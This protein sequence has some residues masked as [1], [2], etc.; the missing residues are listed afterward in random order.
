MSGTL[1]ASL[2]QEEAALK[3]QELVNALADTDYVKAIQLAFELRRP[4]KLLN[5]F[6]EL[7][8]LAL[9]LI[10]L[11]SLFSRML[12]YFSDKNTHLFQQRVC[13]RSD[14]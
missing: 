6:I 10:W 7:Y 4:Y 2:V 12:H 1:Y 13:Q 11:M 3:D 14:T 9:A 5:V 8:K